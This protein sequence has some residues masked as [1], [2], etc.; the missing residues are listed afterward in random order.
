[1]GLFNI[2]NKKTKYD[3]ILICIGTKL[4]NENRYEVP[5][6]EDLVIYFVE[7]HKEAY[8]VLSKDD[9]ES[10]NISNEDL[11]R[12]AKENTKKKIYNT[13]SGVPL[14][15]NEEDQVVFP[16]DYDAIIESGNYNFWTSLILFDEFW[17]KNSEF[18]LEKNWDRYY[19][20]MPY[21]TFL[22]IGNADNE[23]SKKEIINQLEDYKKQDKEE[24]FGSGDYE[25]GRRSISNDLFIIDK[26]KLS[27]YN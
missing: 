27:K 24:L 7:N 16:Y 21:R 12:I 14:R 5:F 9:Y 10:M 22:L 4:D 17:N 23:K 25:A 2:F 1:M 8:K 3:K 6:V 26:G 18:C 20:A 13:Y 15:V 19:I 11:I